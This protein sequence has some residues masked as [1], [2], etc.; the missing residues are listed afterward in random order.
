MTVLN[1]ETGEL[2]ELDQVAAR[3]LTDKIKVGVE[4]VWL[5]I[6]QAYT[7]RAWQALGY[8]SWDNYTTREFGTSHLKL[9]RED[10]TEII[11]S[12]RD[13]GLSLRAIGSATG[14]S[15]GTVHAQLAGVQNRTPAP[16]SSPAG[17]VQATPS[18][19][20]HEEESERENSV[21]DSA[22]RET[23]VGIDGKT[24]PARGTNRARP[25]PAAEKTLTTI[26][27]FA[28]R[29]SR[30]AQKLTADQIRRVKPNAAEWIDGIRNSMEVLQDLLRSLEEN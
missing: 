30:E 25:R 1:T 2:V 16:H 8:K 18:F 14:L 9:P 26:E 20:A 24:Y 29:A 12:M 17:D 5:L 23:V 15:V 19:P 6:E 27:Y 4:G 10:R 7:S 22:Q 11:G 21:P 13:A 3:R 28:N